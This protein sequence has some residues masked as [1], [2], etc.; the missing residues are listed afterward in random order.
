MAK[1]DWTTVRIPSE[2]HEEIKEL[3]ELKKKGYRTIAQ[4]VNEAVRLRLEY[5]YK[6]EP[7]PPK[8]DDE[9]GKSDI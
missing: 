5:I 4:F 9:D 1:D 8:G 6:L 7:Q 3:I 2:L